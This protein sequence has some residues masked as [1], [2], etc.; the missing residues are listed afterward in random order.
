M[1]QVSRL[2]L[3]AAQG[4]DGVAAEAWLQAGRG[5]VF[6]GRY[7]DGRC[8]DEAMLRASDA[9][10]ELPAG[11]AVVAEEELLAL[12]PRLRLVPAGLV[13]AL[14]L[15]VRRLQDGEAIDAGQV[16][17]NYL[18]VP[19]AELAQQARTAALTASA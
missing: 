14:P 5:D 19:D 3:L 12:S 1:V 2:A 10:A 8:L 15:V 9:L 18:R 13:E 7:S 17:A 6:R 11:G 4:S 16:A